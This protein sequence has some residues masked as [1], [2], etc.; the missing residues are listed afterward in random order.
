[1]KLLLIYPTTITDGKPDK[2]RKIYLPPLN[3]AILDRLTEL[4]DPN[5]DVKIINEYVEHID[6]DLDCDLVGITALTSQARRAYQIADQFRAKGKKV[7]LGG[8]HPSLLP[9]EALQ[10]AD[11]VAIGEVEDNWSDILADFKAGRP[12]QIYKTDSFPDLK[13]LIIPKWDNMD[14]SLCRRSV[15]RKMPRMPIYTT[16]GCVYDCDFCSVSKFFGRTYRYKPIENVLKEIETTNAESYF[17]TD[18]NIIC[19]RSYAEELFKELAKL[20]NRPRWFSQAST[21]LVDKPELISQASKAGCR[22]LFFGV[23]SIFQDTLASINKKI[24]NPSRYVDLYQNCMAEGIQ[25]WFSMIFGFDHDTVESAWETV[26]FLKQNKIWNVVF[27]VLTPFPATNLYN[28]MKESNRIIDTDWS[29][30]DAAHIVYRP[31]HFTTK[32]LYNA[33]WQLYRSMFTPI[34]MIQRL[35]QARKTSNYKTLLTQYYYRKQIYNFSH[36]Y[37]LGI[38]KYGKQTI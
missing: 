31:V 15:G 27:W 5:L 19:N 20:K 24:N 1:M 38:G 35:L 22:N 32:E 37:N 13:K 25:P 3:L 14:L 6:Y 29:R 33:F 17:F 21:N 4:A 18:D 9:E 23:E 26:Q 16:R 12:K 34:S 2:Y 8:V 36:P 11:A 30:Y 7:I 28:G 10:H